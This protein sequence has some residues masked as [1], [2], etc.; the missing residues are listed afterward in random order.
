MNIPIE[1]IIFTKIL[2]KYSTEYNNY[3]F[4]TNITKNLN[5][6]LNDLYIKFSIYLMFK[7]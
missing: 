5:I 2:T 3:L 6:N 7:Y 4:I 1:K